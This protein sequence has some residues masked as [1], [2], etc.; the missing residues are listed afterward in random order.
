[1]SAPSA[2]RRRLPAVAL[3]VVVWLVATIGLRPLALPEEGRYVGVAWEML[4]SGHWLVPTEDGLPF[5][6]KPPLF[7]WLDA[8]SMQL[9]GLHPA[10][11]RL[12]SVLA[13]LLGVAGV[14]TVAHRWAGE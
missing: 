14:R 4:R 13:A 9:F 8:A 10:A 7:Y 12:P 5:F 2:A 3:L 11:A 1:M 6:H